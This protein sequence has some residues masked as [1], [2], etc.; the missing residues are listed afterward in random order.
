MKVIVSCE[1][2]VKKYGMHQKAHGGG[3]LVVNPVDCF[4]RDLDSTTAFPRRP[5]SNLSDTYFLSLQA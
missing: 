4:V 1:S 3:V 5:P 2:E